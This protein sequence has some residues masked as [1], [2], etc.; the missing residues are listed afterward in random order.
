[1]TL[2]RGGVMDKEPR[3]H[4]FFRRECTNKDIEC[5]RCSEYYIEKEGDYP[6]TDQAEGEGNGWL[7]RIFT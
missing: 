5:H 2:A 3:C 7:Q 4:A 1:M 6:L